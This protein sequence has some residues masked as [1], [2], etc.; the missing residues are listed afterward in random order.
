MPSPTQQQAPQI[1][2]NGHVELAEPTKRAAIEAYLAS[3]DADQLATTTRSQVAAELTGRGLS[4]DETYAGRILGEWRVRHPAP[5][6][7]R[8]RGSRGR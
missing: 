7:A 2:D 3:L 6:S 1:S 8:K 5:V 4:V